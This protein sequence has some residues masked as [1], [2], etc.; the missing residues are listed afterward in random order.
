MCGIAG[1]I[2]FDGSAPDVEAVAR[3]TAEMHRRGPDGSGVYSVGA[4]ALGHRRLKIIDLSERGAQPMVDPELGLSAVF[5]GLIYNYRELRAELEAAGYHFFSTSD[6]EVLLKAFKHWGPACVER[7]LGMFAFAVAD[8]DTGVLTLGRDRLGIKPLYLAEAHG[9]LLFASSLPALLKAGGIDTSID[10]IALHHYMTFHSVVPAPRTI[11]SGVRK[12]PPATVRTIQPDGTS[13][14]HLY[15]EPSHIRRPEHA[16]MSAR[17]WRDAVLESLRIA[18]RRRMVADVPVGVLL[19]GGLDSSLVVALLA[20]EGQTGLQTFSVGFHAAAGESGDEFEYSDLVAEH[21]G[22]EHQQILVD[23]ARML[24]AVDDAIVA[25]SEPMV[26]HDCVAFYLLAQ[27][28]SKSVRVVQSG[29]GADE[30]FAGYSWYPPL[31]GVPR[32]QGVEAYA[33][34]FTDRPHAELAHILEPEWV[35]DHDPSRAFIAEHFGAPGADETLDAA[36]RLDSTIMLVDDPVKRVDNMT[37]A[38]GLEARVPFLDHELVELA[39]ACPPELK[40]AH[41]GKGVL[42]DAARGVVPDSIIDRPKGYFPVPAIRHLEGPF[43]DRVRDAVTDPV[44]KARGLVRRDWLDTML[45]DPN[46]ARTNLGSNA[47]WQV[48]LLE[49]WFQERGL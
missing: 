11:L 8:R 32:A 7:F 13:S 37:M 29:Q 4:I 17:D 36:L 35:L 34:Q 21:F 20:A 41:G 45:A 12:L 42:K 6:T 43:L 25:M 27:E 2:R 15:W 38:W 9:R 5:N 3:V 31:A 33:K 19:S 39:A 44:A 14:D 46:T 22:T 28:V 40:L 48:A 18:V 1:E 26:S 24:P 23:P 49:M 30:V 10:R 16:G 47:L